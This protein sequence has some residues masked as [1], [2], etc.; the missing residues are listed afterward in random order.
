M[1]RKVFSMI[2]VLLVTLCLSG[3][4]SMNLGSLRFNTTI[5]FKS[6]GKTDVSI[7][8]ATSETL[9][10][11]NELS[12]GINN[13]QVQK[14]EEEGWTVEQYKEDEYSGIKA[15]KKD[16]SISDMQELFNESQSGTSDNSSIITLRKDG[17]NYVFDSNMFESIAGESASL[18]KSFIE[19]DDG[20]MTF[21]VKL[22]FKAVDSNATSV[23]D[24][25]R[26][27]EWDLLSMKDPNIHFV[28]SLINIKL[29]IGVLISVLVL[30]VA[31][32]FVFIRSKKNK[33][34][35]YY[36]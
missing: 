9:S 18:V 15:I 29:I 22:P 21:V 19:M 1:K 13:E 16:L 6:N 5:E 3:C 28:F 17:L 33:Q 14:M 24:D 32:V 26:T 25:G 4:E 36:R 31:C 23:L 7:M 20:Y 27:L 34:R 8:Y 2:I 10:D 12:N 35:M 30:I 11:L